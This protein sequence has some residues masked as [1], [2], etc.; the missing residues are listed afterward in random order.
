MFNS[1]VVAEINVALKL[2][3]RVKSLPFSG[4][5]LPEAKPIMGSGLIINS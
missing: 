5:K 2:V 4:Y 3:F 1:R